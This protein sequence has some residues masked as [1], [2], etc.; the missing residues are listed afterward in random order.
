MI[1]HDGM[2][3][4]VSGDTR[5]RVRFFNGE[6]DEGIAKEF[7]W[8][9][10]MSFGDD[11]YDIIEYEVTEESNNLED[12]KIVMVNKEGVPSF[13]SLSVLE[14][15][16]SMNPQELDFGDN[17]YY[18]LRDNHFIRIYEQDVGYSVK[19]CSINV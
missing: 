18:V 13:V 4:P 8:G 1:K 6:T 12:M 19:I 16:L 14:N 9:W 17:K 2:K 10:D 7:D 5:V 15:I 11:I 3:M